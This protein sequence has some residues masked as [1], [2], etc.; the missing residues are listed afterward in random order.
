MT[1]LWPTEQ[2]ELKVVTGMEPWSYSTE[3][4]RGVVNSLAQERLEGIQSWSEGAPPVP[5]WIV[6]DGNCFHN[7]DLPRDC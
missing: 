4:G 1:V 6:L 5:E 7:D 2:G 3:A